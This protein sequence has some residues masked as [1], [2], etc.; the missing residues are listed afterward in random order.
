MKLLLQIVALICFVMIFGPV[1]MDIFAEE[2]KDTMW[3]LI[4]PVIQVPGL[5]IGIVSVMMFRREG[6]NRKPDKPPWSE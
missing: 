6:Y 2:S 4:Y 1:L 5:I 3:L